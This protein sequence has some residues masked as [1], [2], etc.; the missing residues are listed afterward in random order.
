[1]ER[2]ALLKLN[3]L[4]RVAKHQEFRGISVPKEFYE[5]HISPLL[6]LHRR[7]GVS[8]G[9]CHEGIP[10]IWQEGLGF[11]LWRQT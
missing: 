4:A 1:M 5:R 11:G 2:K 7:P 9:Y 3:H 6:N 10:V 8:I